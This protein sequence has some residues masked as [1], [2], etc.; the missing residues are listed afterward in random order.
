MPKTSGSTSMEHS[1]MPMEGK[2][3]SMDGKAMAM[4]HE[5]MSTGS[6]KMHESM[7]KGMEK[8]QSMTMTDNTDQ[9]FAMMMMEHHKAA[10]DMAQ[11]ELKYGKDAKL[12]SM[13]R[14]IVASQKAEI[15]ELERW[16]ERHNRTM[17]QS[18]S[19]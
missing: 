14:N 1:G 17:S 6:K 10:M 16:Q 19:D 3:M 11:I 2:N 18:K 8:M 5:G 7:M 9:D 4:N 15:K 12:R 13:A